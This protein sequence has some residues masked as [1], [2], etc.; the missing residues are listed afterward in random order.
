MGLRALR[1]RTQLPH[2][3]G[4]LNGEGWGT[5]AHA[6]DTNSH[7]ATSRQGPAFPA[8]IRLLLRS[9]LWADSVGIR[10]V[11]ALW[12]AKRSRWFEAV[13]GTDGSQGLDDQRRWL[14]WKSDCRRSTAVPTGEGPL[15]GWPHRDLHLEHGLDRACDVSW[16]TVTALLLQ[17]VVQ[18]SPPSSRPGLP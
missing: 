8:A 7:P 13:A 12:R 16:R 15:R 10:P 6:T 14:L 3:S 17:P 11:P 18:A 9:S 2:G 1:L 4:H 5:D